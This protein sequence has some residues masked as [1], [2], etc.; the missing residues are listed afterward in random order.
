MATREL[1]T[2]PSAELAD[3]EMVIG[4]FDS[5]DQAEDLVRKLIDAGIPPAHISI[6]AKDLQARERV[7]GYV[8]MG[9]M[10]KELAGMGAWVGGL[11]G[12][13]AGATAFL[14]LPA[15]GPLI[16]LG[17]LVAGAIGALEG[18]LVG[19]LIGAIFGER[20]ERD[21]VLKYEQDIQAGKVLVAVH[22]TPDELARVRSLMTESGI[23]DVSTIA[24]QAA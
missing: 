22:G 11:F 19:G 14:W 18:G 1:S 6:I 16:V 7:T 24:A 9:E 17:P 4:V 20:L 13:L 23:D 3:L 2:T 10:A 8:T 5:H 21:R 15:V 12:L